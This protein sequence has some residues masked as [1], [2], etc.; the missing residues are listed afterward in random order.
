MLKLQDVHYS[1]ATVSEPV[2][3]GVDLTAD[4]GCP[5]LI[6]GSS[7][8]GKTS[9]LDVISGL[10]GEQSGQVSWRGQ[11]LTRRQRRWLCGLVFSF[12]NYFL[13]FTVAQELRLGQRRMVRINNSSTE[14]RAIWSTPTRV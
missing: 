8:S 2:L 3:C 5:L 12:R 13:V 9:L 14:P 11:T 6:A 7:G 10:S 4:V 1:P